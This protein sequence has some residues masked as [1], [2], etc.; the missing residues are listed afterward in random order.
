MQA[1][2]LRHRVTIQLPVKMQ[3][4]TTGGVDFSWTTFAVNVPAA[5]EPLSVGKFLAA[6]QVQS[7]ISTMITIRWRSGLQP[8]MRVLHGATIYDVIGYLPDKDTNRDYV[9][10]PCRA[11]VN[12]ID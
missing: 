1:G 3:N 2:K 9:T 11:G 10:L 5:V 8:N 6:Q 7:E 12:E 4:D